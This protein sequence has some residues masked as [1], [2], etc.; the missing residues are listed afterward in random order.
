MKRTNLLAALSV[1]LLFAPQAFAETGYTFE[2]TLN[3]T[4]NGKAQPTLVVKNTV[5]G[6]SGRVDIPVDRD[7]WKKGDYLLTRDGGQTFLL[8]SPKRKT[9]KT[10][11]PTTLRALIEN[12]TKGISVSKPTTH[13]ETVG[14]NQ[15]RQTRG[16][17]IRFRQGLISGKGTMDEKHDYTLA[18]PGTDGPSFNPM[19]NYTL[20]ELASL[21]LKNPEFTE[22]N[23][24]AALPKGFVL[25]AELNLKSIVR[26]NI[27]GTQKEDGRTLLETSAPTPTEVSP[28]LFTVPTDYKPAK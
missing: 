6:L 7:D 15:E 16:Y 10:L 17:E 20:L 22:T 8:V 2:V 12:D 28:A 25:R 5:S 14:T 9:V 1:A 3:G 26:A 21:L 18:S 27:G 11:T 23:L 24:Y 13:W 19:V 4:N